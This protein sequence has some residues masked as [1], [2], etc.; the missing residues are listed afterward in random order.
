[1]HSI[2]H[3]GASVL[4]KDLLPLA[5]LEFIDV[6]TKPNVSLG[7]LEVLVEAL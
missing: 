2:P 1:M 5:N 6:A 7:L 4:V 3:K